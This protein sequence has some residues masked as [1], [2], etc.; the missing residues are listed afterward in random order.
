[1][2]REIPRIFP[3]EGRSARTLKGGIVTSATDLFI[4]A[5]ALRYGLTLVTGNVKHFDDIPRLKVENW[6]G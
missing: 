6:I 5:I 4:A 1:M 2:S 3:F